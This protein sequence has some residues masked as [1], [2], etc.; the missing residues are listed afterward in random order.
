M[1]RRWAIHL[2]TVQVL[3]LVCAPSDGA[4]F[5]YPWPRQQAAGDTLAERIAPPAGF[6]RISAIEGSFADWMR[7]LPLR[8]PGAAVRFFDGRKKSD[9]SGAFAVVDIDVGTRDFQ[10]CAD[11]IMR[12]RA[13][14]LLAAGCADTIRFNF[15]SGHAARWLDWRAG[16]RPLVSG[17]KVSWVLRAEEDSSYS[18]FRE[19]LDTVFLYAGTYSLSKEMEPVTD[20]AAVLP[21]DVFIQGDFPGHAVLVADVAEDELGQRIFLLLQSF[22]PAQDIHVLMNPARPGTP[23]YAAF[24]NGKLETPDWTF[25]YRDLRRFTQPDCTV[26]DSEGA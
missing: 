7:G 17:R 10:Q 15:S 6:T 5:D 13:E 16:L 22:M 8:E 25:S 18:A 11:A 24:K 9:Q 19:Y 1:E 21:G 20:P 12:L 26:S 2:V 23:W 3:I 4:A 14:Y